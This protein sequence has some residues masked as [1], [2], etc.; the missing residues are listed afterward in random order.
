MRRV[1]TVILHLLL[2]NLYPELQAEQTL[3]VL[4]HF[5]QF[6]VH[7]LVFFVEVVLDVLVDWDTAGLMTIN[8]RRRNPS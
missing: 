3:V 7:G 4:L 2:S 8:A 5:T 6:G 1:A